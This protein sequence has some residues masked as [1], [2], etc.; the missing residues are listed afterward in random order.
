MTVGEK[1]RNMT[2]E[3][4]TTYI[5]Y[6]TC[7]TNDCSYLPCSKF[8]TDTGISCYDAILKYLKTLSK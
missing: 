1:I 8:C 7:E 4:L 2:D 5:Q 3:E 6:L